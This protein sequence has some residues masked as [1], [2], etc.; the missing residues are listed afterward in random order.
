LVSIPSEIPGWRRNRRHAAALL[1]LAVVAVWVTACDA[2]APARDAGTATA[3]GAAQ[4]AASGG[5][6]PVGAASPGATSASAPASPGASGVRAGT[7]TAPAYA[8]E[9][10]TVVKRL[11]E[12]GLL[13]RRAAGQVSHAF[14]SVPGVPVA[15]GTK[16]DLEVFIYA[17]SIAVARDVSLLDT[18]TVAPRGTRPT[19]KAKATLI[20]NNNLAAI[21]LAYNEQF[22]E[23]VQ[24]LLTAGAPAPGTPPPARP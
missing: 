4:Q 16:G 21:L 8:W 1:A 13:P 23:R 6:A 20:T 22:I 11:T 7:L 2:G 18:A 5:A 24:L 10:G 19:W 14:M 3:T 9:I 17:D 12:G 15:L